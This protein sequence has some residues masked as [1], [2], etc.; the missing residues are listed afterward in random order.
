MVPGRRARTRA[1]RHLARAPQPHDLGDVGRLRARVPQQRGPPAPRAGAQAARRRGHAG[2]GRSARSGG[3][4]GVRRGHHRPTSRHPRAQGARAQRPARAHRR[5]RRRR[6]R[7]HLPGACHR[8]AVRPGDPV[9]A[10]RG[11]PG[12]H[13]GA[14][15]R[16]RRL[17]DLRLDL[18]GP[19]LPARPAWRGA[20]PRRGFR[21][22][23]PRLVCRHHRS[24]TGL[25]VVAGQDAVGAGVTAPAPGGR[26]SGQRPGVRGRPRAHRHQLHPRPRGRSWARSCACGG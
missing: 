3:P 2:V 4:V 18:R 9:P 5:R 22:A 24:R 11:P 20:P 6:G 7:R 8:R 15:R 14:D 26:G 23:G 19:L 12:S 10:R 13:P 21:R 16:G 25:A 1:R 17:P